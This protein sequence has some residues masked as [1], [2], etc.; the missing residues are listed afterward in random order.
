MLSQFEILDMGKNTAHQYAV[1]TQSL[2]MHN[3]LIGAND[4][5]IAAAAL[6][7]SLPLVTNNSDHFKRIAGLE[8]VDY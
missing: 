3:Q 2:R 5:W 6:E 1:L 4:H 7:H 8:V